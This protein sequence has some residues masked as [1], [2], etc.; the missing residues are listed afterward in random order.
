VA[1]L[2]GPRQ[3]C[4]TA[5]GCRAASNDIRFP[6]I[7]RSGRFDILWTKLPGPISARCRLC[8]QASAWS[9]AGRRPGRAADQ[10]RFRYQPDH[11]QGAGAH[12]PRII[13]PARRRGDRIVAV[14]LHLL[15]AGIGTLRRPPMSVIRSLSGANRTSASV[16]GRCSR[17]RHFITRN[18]RTARLF[19]RSACRVDVAHMMKAVSPS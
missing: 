9:K 1:L 18:R 13:S 3:L 16:R 17:P 6:G 4:P 10:I 19:G 12:H 8:R 14:L 2:V 7:R 15:V 11:R 5:G